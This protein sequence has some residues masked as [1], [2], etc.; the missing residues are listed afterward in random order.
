MQVYQCT[1]CGSQHD[2]ATQAG[3][4]L[5]DVCAAPLAYHGQEASPWGEH[6]N[7]RDYDQTA[8]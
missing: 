3:G 7:L 6:P 1:R 2:F 4:R 5:C 8:A